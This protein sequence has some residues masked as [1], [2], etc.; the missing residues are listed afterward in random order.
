MYLFYT[1]S[2]EFAVTRKLLISFLMFNMNTK[3]LILLSAKYH[4][5]GQL[6]HLPIFIYGCQN[7]TKQKASRIMYYRNPRILALEEQ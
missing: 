5:F 3:I 2:T 6:S 7:K 4:I 1:N